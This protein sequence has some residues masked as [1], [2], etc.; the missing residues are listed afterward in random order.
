M[1]ACVCVRAGVFW[2]QFCLRPRDGGIVMAEGRW[3]E[4]VEKTVLPAEGFW[5]L[6][7]SQRKSQGACLFTDMGLDQFSMYH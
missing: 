2:R 5:H 4:I 6:L 7:C 1:P 3:E